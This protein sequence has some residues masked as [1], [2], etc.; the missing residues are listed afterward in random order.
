MNFCDWS[1]G[2]IFSFANLRCATVLVLY[3]I[4]YFTLLCQLLV[5]PLLREAAFFLVVRPLKQ[6]ILCGFPK[7]Q[8]WPIYV[9]YKHKVPRTIVKCE[10]STGCFFSFPYLHCSTPAALPAVPLFL[11]VWSGLYCRLWS[12]VS[13]TV[14][15]FKKRQREKK[16]KERKIAWER[17]REKREDHILRDRFI[18]VQFLCAWK[19]KKV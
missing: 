6:D 4:Q 11:A 7:L 3:I 12:F 13:S 10:L 14:I 19:G 16:E 15:S 5:K 17:D 1:T 18:I 9:I 8:D 2:C